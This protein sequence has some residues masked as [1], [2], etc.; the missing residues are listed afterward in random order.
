MFSRNGHALVKPEILDG[1]MAIFDSFDPL[2]TNKNTPLP[3]TTE[4]DEEASTKFLMLS[5]LD[6]IGLVQTLYPNRPT[7]SDSH[8]SEPTAAVSDRPSTAGSSTLINTSSD[9]GSGLAPSTAPSTAEASV[10]SNKDANELSATDQ[11]A[12][13]QSSHET[14]GRDSKAE[15]TKANHMAQRDLASQLV[16]ACRQVKNILAHDRVSISVA[17]PKSWDLIYYSK[18]GSAIIVAPEPKA[19]D[20]R[21]PRRAGESEPTGVDN[22]DKDYKVLKTAVTKLLSEDDR[23]GLEALL[24]LA[25]SMTTDTESHHD[26]LE[27][28]WK[29]L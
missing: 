10:I 9:A 23:S 20:L 21:G 27:G 1:V 14:L 26:P 12:P 13:E 19:S 22:H 16:A 3:P 17:S 15:P 29:P 8:E 25:N 24:I 7:S 4:H 11:L 2:A 5:P 18:E 6:I 28:S